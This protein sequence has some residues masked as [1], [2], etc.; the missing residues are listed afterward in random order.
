MT[1]TRVYLCLGVTYILVSYKDCLIIYF[2]LCTVS[3]PIV[4]L[5][6]SCKKLYFIFWATYRTNSCSI[7]SV[8]QK[9]YNVQN[10]IVQVITQPLER[11]SSIL[12]VFVVSQYIRVK[13]NVGLQGW[14]FLLYFYLGETRKP[15]YM[16]QSVLDFYTT[17]FSLVIH[18]H[19]YYIVFSVLMAQL[20]AYI[21]YIVIARVR[22][23]LLKHECYSPSLLRRRTYVHIS[24]IAPYYNI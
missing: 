14:G 3:V 4:S 24:G 2:P 5:H 11:G 19:Y 15:E 8:L 23:I 1:Y 18:F 13:E 22:K 12:F 21:L 10:Q 16:R 9:I 7:Y 17:I 6:Q 20:C